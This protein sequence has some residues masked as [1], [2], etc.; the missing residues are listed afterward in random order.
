MTWV[1]KFEE[2]AGRQG[3]EL[4]EDA[5]TEFAARTKH[6]RSD[7]D[8]S[9]DAGHGKAHVLKNFHDIIDLKERHSG[10]GSARH[11]VVRHQLCAPDSQAEP[12]PGRISSPALR[13]RCMKLSHVDTTRLD[14]ARNYVEEGQFWFG[15]PYTLADGPGAHNPQTAYQGIS[16]AHARVRIPSA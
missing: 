10:F 1:G 9:A 5:G 7:S 15:R 14:L 16:R 3:T 12:T 2:T 13:V 8:T 11:T 6:L 4:A